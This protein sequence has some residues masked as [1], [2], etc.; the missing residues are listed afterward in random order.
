MRPGVGVTLPSA[1]SES[2]RGNAWMMT[3]PLSEYV[4]PASLPSAH[5]TSGAS[6]SRGIP[7]PT[8]DELRQGSPI[9]AK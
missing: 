1:A 5:L 4:A 8:R 3:L 7:S 9:T 2:P 6:G